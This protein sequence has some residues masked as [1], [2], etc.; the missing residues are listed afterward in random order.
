[1]IPIPFGVEFLS[2]T[3]FVLSLFAAG[4]FGFFGVFLLILL[5]PGYDGDVYAKDRIQLGW[6]LILA[7]IL[8]FV[9]GWYL[10]LPV[11]V[12]LI[13]WVFYLVVKSATILVKER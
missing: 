9:F 5:V 2:E 1:M 8:F 6:Q 11:V 13:I 10:I 4:I 12:A 7:A 3:Q